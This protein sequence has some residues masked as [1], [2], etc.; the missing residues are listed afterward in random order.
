[1][2][3]D[4]VENGFVVG[5]SAP[6]K[7]VVPRRIDGA[8]DLTSLGVPRAHEVDQ[9]ANGRKLVG[10][11]LLQI[12][13]VSAGFFERTIRV[14]VRGGVRFLGIP[15]LLFEFR[16]VGVD[17]LVVERAGGLAVVLTVDLG[18]PGD[19]L[20]EVKNLLMFDPA[21]GGLGVE[22][23]DNFGGQQRSGE[24]P[25]GAARCVRNSCGRR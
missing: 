1:V 6:E 11:I 24:V 25:I 19:V 12:L 15:L 18:K 2:T 22:L 8:K 16:F 10:P 21:E 4:L 5:R 3:E 23:V 7:E 9:P 17:E 13:R 14:A 20:A